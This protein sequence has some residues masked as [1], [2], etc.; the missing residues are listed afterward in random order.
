M[1]TVTR[2]GIIF[3]LIAVA[4]LSATLSVESG[5]SA[6]TPDRQ[7]ISEFPDAD[8]IIYDGTRS[9]VNIMKRT[10]AF[11]SAEP[12]EDGWTVTS[13]MK[14]GSLT[15][16]QLS[17]LKGDLNVVMVSGSLSTVNLL[18]VDHRDDQRDPCDVT[19]TM[20][21]GSV[22][23]LK[24]LTVSSS[25]RSSLKDHYT[26]MYQPLGHISIDLRSADITELSPTEDMVEASD[27]EIKVSSGSTVDRIFPSGKNGR[28]GS[29]Y[30]ELDGGSVGYMTNLKA[31]VGSLEYRFRSGS[32]EYFCIGADTEYGSNYSLSNI[33]SFYARG[34]VTVDMDPT[35]S[36][37]SVIIGSGI[38]EL[39]AVL[40]NGDKISTNTIETSSKNVLIDAK[41]TNV[42][43]DKCFRT[44]NRSQNTCYQLS[45]YTIGGNARTKSLSSYCYGSVIGSVQVYGKRGIWSSAS[46]MEIHTGYHLMISGLMN[47][48]S[49][50]TVTVSKGASLT[51]A[52]QL[53]LGGILVNE[54]TVNNTGV[55]EKGREGSIEGN[56][57]GNGYIA[58]SISV[59]PREDGS[60]D[61]MASDDDSV[62][63]R[64]NDTILIK[65]ISVLLSNGDYEV[66]ISAP[67]S[68]Y[69]EGNWFLVSLKASKSDDKGVTYQLHIDGIDKAILS[70][71]TV[72]VT[73]PMPSNSE[74]HVYRSDGNEMAITDMS[75]PDLT[76]IA[77]GTGT[78][79]VTD[80]SDE[81]GTDA[82][83]KNMIM[84]YALAASIVLVG[85]AT[86][87]ML[88]RK[89]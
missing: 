16:A 83:R 64:S 43:L 55:I 36:Y 54:G 29:V 11:N 49:G 72:S 26:I 25:V 46:D 9:S 69:F 35:V 67:P 87:Y 20:E 45:S 48:P 78:Y 76:F 59:T 71:L 1:R 5:D 32:I 75:Y 65:S 81:P 68:M 17:E 10:N 19:F 6:I 22:D 23:Y 15:V 89:D 2:N 74:Y 33:N 52:N 3:A 18:R 63:I 80:T 12:S 57:S 47:I 24:V 40:W 88:L 28:Y 79:R 66:H 34:S 30:M 60:I 86:V 51:I 73:I 4:L 14:G 8:V 84:N 39:P 44:S 38:M 31:V 58:Y 85:V 41:D 50:V 37:R 21:G 77:E 42:D 61:V 56:V 27:I 7:L 70:S 82:T 62:V 53:Y 13:V